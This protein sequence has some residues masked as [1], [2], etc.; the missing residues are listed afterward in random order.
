REALIAGSD[1]IASL[2]NKVRSGGRVDAL[3]TLDIVRTAGP[4][5]RA[6]SPGPVTAQ[7]N[8]AN[9]TPIDRISVTFSRDIDAQFLSTSAFSLRGDGPD[10]IANN[11]DDYV[12]PATAL[13]VSADLRTVTIVLNLT[14]NLPQSGR[15]PLDQFTMV[16]TASGFRDTS[17]NLLNGNTA[18][19]VDYRYFFEVLP[20]TGAYEQNDTIVQ[21]TAVVFDATGTAR[22]SGATIG[23]GIN[24]QYDVDLFRIDL[25]RGGLITA[26]TFAQRLPVTSSLDSVIRLFTSDG[27][28]VRDDAGQAI[29][30]DQAI[31]N[32]SYFEFFVRTGGVYYVGVSG[33]G[34][35]DYDP[36]VAGV[37]V[38]QSR[39]VYDLR[40]SLDLVEN[41]VIRY[42]SA[43][44]GTP[45]A[46][47][48]RIPS[49]S[50][51]TSGN[52][53]RFINVSDTRNIL[54][55]NVRISLLHEYTSDLQISLIS[56]LGTIVRLFSNRGGN[57]DNLGTFDPNNGSVLRP[58]LFDDE[59]PVDISAGVAPFVS[60]GFRPESAL[61][62]FDGEPASG[63]VPWTL[64]INDT[65]PQH[66]GQLIAW[67]IEFTLDTEISG[68]FELND[69]LS[70]AKT[71]A[72]FD[73]VPGQSAGG[74]GNAQR[75]AFLGDGAF[76]SKDRDLFKFQ[77]AAGGTLTA[78][79]ISSG[80]LNTALRLFD[81]QGVEIVLSNPSDSRDA[82]IE[83]YVFAF[84]GEYYIG[85][86]DGNNVTYTPGVANNG[87]D[88]ASAST[89]GFT[90]SVAIAAGVSDPGT[91]LDGEDLAVAV[92]S[93]GNFGVGTSGLIFGGAEF[94]PGTGPKEQF[95]GGS[96]G[97]YSFSNKVKNASGVNADESSFDLPFSLTVASDRFNQRLSTVGVFRGLRIERVI[98]YGQSDSFIA[99]DVF[100]S[101]TTASDLA[102][103]SWMEGLN[104]DQGL[105]LVS[106][107]RR[108]ANT[109]NDVDATGKFA[110]A[111]FTDNNFANGL[112]IGIAAPVT[113][114]R[115]SATVLA[116]GTSPRDS[117]LLVSSGT[118]D[119][120]G[121]ESDSILAMAF[122][123][124]DL[125]AGGT[126]SVRYF[127][128]F[129]A[130]FADVQA[131]NTAMNNGSG[132]GHLA[133]DSANP[134]SEALITESTETVQTV[135]SLPYREYFPEGF[136]GSNV[137]TFIPVTNPNSQ[138]TRVVLVA[139]F[140]AG[141][142]DAQGI[143]VARDQVL[144]DFV[145][146]ANSRDGLTLVTPELF[147]SGNT[148]LRARTA[149]PYAI[150]LRSERPVAATF[151]HYD[152]NLVSGTPT[153]VG[154]AF[155]TR[156][157]TTWTFGNLEWGAGH[158]EFITLFNPNDANVKVSA[159]FYPSNGGAP[160][161]VTRDIGALR[162]SG[163]VFLKDFAGD[164][165]LANLADGTYGVVLSAPLPFVASITKY[166]SIA[167]TAEGTVANAGAGSRTG[168]I[169]D[170][171][172]GLTGT[173]ERLGVLNPGATDADV[174]MSFI[175]TGG[176][177][178]RTSLLV[179]ARSQRELV[180]GDLPNFP[181]GE[182]YGLVY[183]SNTA[184]SISMISDTFGEAVGSATA[185]KGYTLW[186]FGE[187]FRP[188]DGDGHPGV[189]DYLRLYNPASTDTVVEISI[190]FYGVNSGETFRRVLP[191]RRITEF[192]VDQFVS[193]ARRASFQF[194]GLAVKAPTPIVAFMGH[195]DRAFPGAFGTLGTPLGLSADIT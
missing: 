45:G 172:L 192:N 7:L 161:T 59:S 114:S 125:A 39:G 76:G 151:S 162:R 82:R 2:Q 99:I 101:N 147:N 119:P 51:D 116:T 113:D 78:S 181:S 120:A 127:L 30:S 163:V 98:S 152:L 182:A 60:S 131:L 74:V 86:T 73:S 64:K 180:V 111:R 146:P 148:L 138:P 171:Q 54:D 87:S 158:T 177:T 14:G 27:L 188:G 16:L 153:A 11:T 72:E 134:G 144:G 57:G 17:R 195:Y 179:P 155:T 165:E 21:A 58:V 18:T 142:R 34:N 65:L 156:V 29:V 53:D 126:A 48:A 124:G 184:V 61:S 37:P 71:L 80:Q 110:T 164:A 112:T 137:Y 159:T 35:D 50:A 79:A 169:P 70:T 121:T 187:G 6:V 41:D 174:V 175:F 83:N 44:N 36:N 102:D 24:G 42:T 38:S 84:S 145:L 8:P 5:V 56:P 28:P 105:G 31:G 118:V 107:N 186:G 96:A 100:F 55:V 85:V 135:P 23:D 49:N 10:N 62:A 139:R 3:R 95:I 15:L 75:T 183:E 1:P 154:E 12:I 20:T 157:E 25:P 141:F 104:P 68:P 109:V 67:E 189:T 185:D 92:N 40:L 88:V 167:R 129:G 90:L 103:V 89:G 160:I 150:E 115:A 13:T 108:T 173:G 166:D 47:P 94:L 136:Y 43:A 26:E 66:I 63:A 117:R 4:V 77:A 194:Y 140:E 143:E 122:D 9:N 132:K 69:S 106:T 178:Y 149:A 46:Y 32:D 176:T 22:Y 168:S 190:S 170:G 123:V 130:A 128:F 81:S 133:A 33:F 97:G 52:T 191:A 19:G 91:R 193:G 93:N